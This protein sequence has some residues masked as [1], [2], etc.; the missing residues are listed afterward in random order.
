MISSGDAAPPTRPLAEGTTN[1][2]VARKIPPTLWVIIAIGAAL[3]LI[4][5]GAKSFWLDEIASVVIARMPGNSFWWWLWHDEGNMALY[6]VMLRPWLGIHLGEAT[7]RLLSVVPG[8]AS[9]P[10]M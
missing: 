9:V 7:V 4:S 8:I 5:L 10:M 3:R 2:T 6:Y 1:P